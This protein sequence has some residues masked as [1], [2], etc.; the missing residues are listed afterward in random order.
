[1]KELL[2]KHIKEEHR[3]KIKNIINDIKSLGY[4]IIHVQDDGFPMLIGGRNFYARK[5]NLLMI[6]DIE[7]FLTLQCNNGEHP[8]WEGDFICKFYPSDNLI[9]A[10][11]KIV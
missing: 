2:K 9:S 4:E 7:G 1:M 11:M 6:Y 8:N 5:G 10:Y 3:D